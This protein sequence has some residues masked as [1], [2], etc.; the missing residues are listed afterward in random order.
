MERMD[1]GSKEVSETEGVRRVRPNRISCTGCY[2]SRQ[3]YSIPYESVL[4]RD[5]FLL[6][7]FD[8]SVVNMLP[9]PL[10]IGDHVPDA[11]LET[12]DGIVIVDVKPEAILLKKWSSFSVTFAA[13][14]KFC[15]EH[16]YSYAFF[17]DAIRNELNDRLE[18][19]KEVHCRAL[20][21]AE[22]PDAAA[23]L[24]SLLNNN[25]PTKVRTLTD[26]LGPQHGLLELRA[27]LCKLISDFSVTISETPSAFLEDASASLKGTEFGLL[28]LLVPYPR[29]VRRLETHPL[30]YLEPHLPAYYQGMQELTLGGHGYDVLDSSLPEKVLV[31]STETGEIYR[32]C[33]DRIP[34]AGGRLSALALQQSKADLLEIQKGRPDLFDRVVR[35]GEAIRGLVSFPRRTREDVQRVANLLELSER[36]V[37]RLVKD[38]ELH[39]IGGLIPSEG[40]GGKGRSRLNPEV[41]EIVRQVIEEQYLSPKKPTVAQIHKDIRLRISNAN[42]IRPQDNRLVAPHIDTIHERVHAIRPS[43]RLREREGDKSAS[44]RFGV[45]GG[46][47]LDASRPLQ[48][49]LVDHTPL[50]VRVVDGRG[51]AFSRVWITALVDAYSRTVGSFLLSTQQPNANAVGLVILMCALS[52]ERE[53]K[54]YE[55]TE[56]PVQGIPWQVHFDNGKDFRSR[57]VAAGCLEFQIAIMHRPVGTPRFGGLIERLFR[58]L[59]QGYIHNL[60]GTTKSNPSDRGIYDSDREAS[61]TI[62]KLEAQVWKI[63]DEYHHSKHS[64]LGMTPLQKWEQ[65]VKR[66]G[67][68]RQLPPDKA[69]KFRTA[70]L[71]MDERRIQKDGIH[72]EGRK[73]Y[74]PS[75]AEFVL[76][77]TKGVGRKV[78]V[79]YDPLDIRYVRVLSSDGLSY[80]RIPAS[81]PFSKP[82]SLR[83]W[84]VARRELNEQGIHTPSEG[85]VLAQYKK[86]MASLDQASDSKIA[87]KQRARTK[88]EAKILGRF[89]TQEKKEDSVEASAQSYNPTSFDLTG[90]VRIKHSD[91]VDA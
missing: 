50:D 33:L 51:R 64:E 3:G 59:E 1:P 85:I 67:Q 24:L 49:V 37:R 69:D 6:S 2:V 7:D 29:L 71:P 5:F 89:S 12:S 43:R 34:A 9:Q 28:N 90:T 4:E 36:Q 11:R 54:E 84:L 47:F 74:S 21:A 35:R 13:T 83:E 76:S 75:L 62:D 65:G 52:K 27:V 14:A 22:S 44:D 46:H 55:L 87:I 39:G 23:S 70:F 68:P 42:E 86:R 40:K 63:I 53:I 58:T 31:K 17:T 15:G 26:Q 78:I 81:I 8:P 77:A 30:R 72:F 16:G 60:P 45:Y 57:L 10:R 73:Y 88:Y 18:V 56:W 19:L 38:F 20:Q 25:G 41:D 82:I 80:Y 91:G 32:V 66:Y 48:T 61:L 79:R